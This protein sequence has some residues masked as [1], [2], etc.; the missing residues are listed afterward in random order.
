[1]A[2]LSAVSDQALVEAVRE[3]RRALLPEAPIQP[4]PVEA[5]L[6]RD[7]VGGGGVGSERVGVNGELKREGMDLDEE[8][9]ALNPMDMVGEEEDEGEE[10]GAEELERLMVKVRLASGVFR[11]CSSVDSDASHR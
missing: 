7:A 10:V 3:V 11:C 4:A 8:E 1:M 2:N 9:E 6:L 5:V